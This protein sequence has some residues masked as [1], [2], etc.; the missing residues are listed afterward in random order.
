M[1]TK[2]IV[3]TLFIFLLTACSGSDTP[4]SNTVPDNVDNQAVV[5]PSVTPTE[6]AS[7]DPT[8]EPTQEASSSEPDAAVSYAA[9]VYP[10]LQS[11][12]LTCHGGE[13]IEGELVMLSYAELMAGSE[14][15]AVI[16]PGDAEGSPLYELASTG[17]MPKRGA[18]LNT[19]QLETILAWINSGALDN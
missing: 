18:N 4:D 14:N 19:V 5:N 2:M 9:D 7:I 15:G 8:A 1:K 13:R 10:I 16:L 11:R 17:K 3:L 12:C 6:A